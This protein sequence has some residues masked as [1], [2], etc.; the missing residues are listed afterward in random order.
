MEFGCCLQ[1]P[2]KSALVDLPLA[3]VFIDFLLL[4]EGQEAPHSACHQLCFHL[5]SKVP[6]ATI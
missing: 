6:G 5:S 3:S 4:L 2:A 1:L